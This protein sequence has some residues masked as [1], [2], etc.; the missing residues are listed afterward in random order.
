MAA[1]NKYNPS[2]SRRAEMEQQGMGSGNNASDLGG[3]LT[4]AGAASGNPYLAAAGIGL[5]AYGSYQQAGDAQQQY[6]L[7][8]KAWQADQDR[9]KRI[10]EEVRRQQQLTNALTE[11]N[12]GQGVKKDAASQYGSYARAYGL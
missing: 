6:E 10:D 1:I 8:V 11:A 5:S 3:G 4:Q 7:M 12:Y 9:Q 2:A